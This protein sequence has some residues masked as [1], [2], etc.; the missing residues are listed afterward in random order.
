M[1]VRVENCFKAA[2]LATGCKMKLDWV[3]CYYDLRNNEGMGEEYLKY[4]KGR[5]G[6]VFNFIDSLGGSTDFGNG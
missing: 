1:K 6:Q 3:M 4:M 2:G 5:Q